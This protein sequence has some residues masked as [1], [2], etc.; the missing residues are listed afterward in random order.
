MNQFLAVVAHVLI[1]LGSVVSVTAAVGVVRFRDTLSRM[2]PATKPQVVGLLFVLAG[3]ML[4]LRGSI[5]IWMLALAGMFTL[6]TAPVIAHRLGRVVYREQLGR[7]G[8]LGVDAMEAD[9]QQ[10]G[11][12]P[13]KR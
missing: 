12:W 8:L 9:E 1:L 7:D 2:H 13:G 5:D 4:S 6:F 11:G 10:H 3:A